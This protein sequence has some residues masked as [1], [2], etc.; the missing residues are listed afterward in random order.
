VT[1]AVLTSPGGNVGSRVRVRGLSRSYGSVRAIDGIDLDLDAGTIVAAVGP[2]GAGK[3]TLLACM[4]GIIRH[5]G[6]VRLDGRPA[7]ALRRGAISYL[8]QRPRLPSAATVGEVLA[9]FSALCGGRPDRV[10]LPEGFVPEADRPLGTLSGGQAQRVALAAAL[11]GGPDLVLLDEPLANLDDAGR[12]AAMEALR[13]HREAGATIVL[14]SPTAVD[15]LTMVDRVVL[16]ERGRL[17]GTGAAASFLGRLAVT[18]WV[19][20]NGA[21]LPDDVE[22]LPNVL[23]RRDRGEWTALDCP[24]EGAVELLASLRAAGVDASRIRIGTPDAALA[25]APSPGEG[26]R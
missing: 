14:A 1:A 18:V 19:H 12:E 7:R 11:A 26:H 13:A 16:L 10:S 4:A 21:S 8:P 23:R 24:E 6:E 25:G 9:L 5:D 3:S 15:L 17:T 2:N 20:R 22:Q